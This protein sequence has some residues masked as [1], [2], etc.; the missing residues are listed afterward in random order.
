MKECTSTLSQHDRAET[1]GMAKGS[2]AGSMMTLLGCQQICCMIWRD[3]CSGGF[4]KRDA[5]QRDNEVLVAR[6]V[7]RPL[8]PM[9][10]AGWAND[11]Q[12]LTWVMSFDGSHSP[13]P[14]AITAASSALVIS[15]QLSA[16]TLHYRKLIYGTSPP[17]LPPHPH[18]P[19]H[20]G[21]RHL[22]GAAHMSRWHDWTFIC[23]TLR[24][25]SA[26]ACTLLVLLAVL[27]N[28]IMCLAASWGL[29]HGPSAR[30]LAGQHA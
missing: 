21:S 6:L 17:P 11:T 20:L 1:V 8:R 2:Y 22:A 13:E 14:L 15:G 4:L 28:L 7:D 18:S 26:L 5:R 24:F 19:S 27:L 12:V 10:P 3:I 16:I 9:F 29:S 25:F 23:L 30:L